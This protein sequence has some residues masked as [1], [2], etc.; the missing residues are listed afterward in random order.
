M[1]QW[2]VYV[3]ARIFDS[4]VVEADDEEAW[5]KGEKEARKMRPVEGVEF[6][7]TDVGEFEKPL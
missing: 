6:V 5:T 7:V 3:E 2:R 4:F 1:N